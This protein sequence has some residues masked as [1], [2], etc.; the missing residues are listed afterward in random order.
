MD[1]YFR[2]LME[3]YILLYR[4]K[5]SVRAVFFDKF[6]LPLRK[7]TL[8]LKAEIPSSALAEPARDRGGVDVP[9]LNFWQFFF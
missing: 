8:P 5:S 7:S 4:W 2:P 1:F 6:T 3:Y 9:S